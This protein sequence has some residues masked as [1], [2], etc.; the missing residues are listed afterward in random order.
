MLDCLLYKNYK[1]IAHAVTSHRFAEAMR[2]KSGRAQ[3]V[4]K[5]KQPLAGDKPG[6][7]CFVLIDCHHAWDF[8]FSCAGRSTGTDQSSATKAESTGL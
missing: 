2:Q 5:T 1:V 8:Y 4:F 6:S 3:D 7:G